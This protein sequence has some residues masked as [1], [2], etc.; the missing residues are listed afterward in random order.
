MR[1]ASCL[2]ATVADP[3][4]LNTS[5]VNDPHG[6]DVHMYGVSPPHDVY[7]TWPSQDFGTSWS[8]G[9]GRKP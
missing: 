4:V 1:V 6:H 5:G 7:S 3:E 8:S 2:Y 9:S